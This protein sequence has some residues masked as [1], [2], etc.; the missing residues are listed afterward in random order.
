MPANKALVDKNMVFLNY[1]KIF[2]CCP[3]IC[4]P[5]LHVKN[6]KIKVREK[7]KEKLS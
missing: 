6:V 1:F 5:P 4:E 3:N 7:R 2:T